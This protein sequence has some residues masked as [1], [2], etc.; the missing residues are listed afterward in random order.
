VVAAHPADTQQIAVSCP[1]VYACLW[2]MLHMES[3]TRGPAPFK[4]GAFWC[5]CRSFCHTWQ[6]VMTGR[7]AGK[8][9]CPDWDLGL[10]TCSCRDNC[11]QRLATSCLEIKEII[12]CIQVDS[13]G[14]FCSSQ[15]TGHQLALMCIVSLDVS[16]SAHTLLLP[17][18]TP[19][20]WLYPEALSQGP[21]E[22]PGHV[23][24]YKHSIPAH[25]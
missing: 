3:W 11:W 17:H 18:A 1:E 19:Q 10:E 15:L 24:S 8:V 7:P 20:L 13:R 16:S 2:S 25:I 22:S 12:A 21:I 9:R 23:S 6:A 4:P 5:S 14:T